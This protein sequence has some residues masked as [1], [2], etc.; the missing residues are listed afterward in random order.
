MH[1]NIPLLKSTNIA[2]LAYARLD[3]R[4]Q[5]APRAVTKAY[6]IT[7]CTEEV[8]CAGHVRMNYDEKHLY[9]II[10]LALALAHH[11]NDSPTLNLQVRSSQHTWKLEVDE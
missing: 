2:C 1:L 9:T 7:C 4:R 10:V 3:H 5:D 11:H 8:K 6:S